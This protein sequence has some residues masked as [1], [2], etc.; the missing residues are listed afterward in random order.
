[1]LLLGACT[2]GPNY[3]PPAVAVPAAYGASPS[4]AARNADLGQWWTAF[5]DPALNG[6]IERAQ[7]GNL[8]VRQAAARVEEAR[9]QQRVVRARGGP[10]L[11]AGA[12][13][14]Y[15][16]LSKNALPA[17]LA[18]LGGGGSSAG[19]S[20][21]GL[22]GEDFAT[23]QTGFD[24]SWEIDL[25]GGQRRANE[26]AAARTD[27]AVW[28][29]RDAEVTLAAEVAR[30]YEQ[31]RALQRRIALADQT[32]AAKREALSFI[33][34]RTAHGLVNTVDERR[35]QQ[36]IEQAAAQREDLLA[37]ADADIHALG[38]LLGLA[39]T[40]VGVDLSGGAAAPP[41]IDVPAGLPSELLRR[42]PDIRAAERR[43]AAATADIGVATADL[44][45]KLSLTGA[46]QLVSRS[47]ATLLESDSL[48]ANG[49]GRL[50]LPLIG[51]GKRQTVALRRTQA[52][53]ALIA[54]E[55][56]I[57]GALRDVEDALTRL[58]ADRRKVTDLRASVAAA[59]DAADTARVR[60]RNGLTP[61]TEV[62]QANQTWLAGRDALA[63]AEAAAVQDEVA[64]YKALGGGWDERRVNEEEPVSGRSS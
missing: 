26:A 51:G 53:E 2:V 50:S 10:S 55:A 61:M 57:I 60:Q 48:F 49:A 30:T 31:F 44:Y 54:Y 43:L 39:P 38:T 52:N 28:S 4:T 36:D 21:I 25:F 1:L 29:Q 41:L 14:G 45:P 37:Q 23:F 18:N 56:A 3:R 24:A 46:L 59:Q 6:L 42:R 35:Q 63:Q 62:L 12:Q 19:A 40:S 8:D 47:L 64:L 34:V 13:A 15:T 58:Q 11:N 16:R 5:G 33:R 9:A 20:P 7:S 32:L 22:P 27:A 17:G